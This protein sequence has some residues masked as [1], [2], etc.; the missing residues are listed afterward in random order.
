[1]PRVYIPVALRPLCDNH[2]VVELEATTV[3][4]VMEVLDTRFPGWQS[5]LCQHGRLRPGWSV[6]VNGSVRPLGLLQAV[7]ADD[8]IHFLP[9]IGGG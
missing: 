2:D 1:M 7:A 4:E 6:C 8:E 5:R 3:A 9:A